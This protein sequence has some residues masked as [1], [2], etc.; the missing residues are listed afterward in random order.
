[1]IAALSTLVRTTSSSLVNS[2]GDNGGRTRTPETVGANLEDKT[3]PFPTEAHPVTPPPT[4]PHEQECI[5]S[6]TIAIFGVAA[7]WQ[8]RTLYVT[9]ELLCIG[10]RGAGSVIERFKLVDILKVTSWRASNKVQS[11]E[12]VIVKDE[13]DCCLQLFIQCPYS[14]A[15]GMGSSPVPQSTISSPVS[16]QSEAT[17]PDISDKALLTPARYDKHNVQI[18]CLRALSSDEREDWEKVLRDCVGRAKAAEIAARLPPTWQENLSDKYN[19]NISQTIV[20]TLVV[21]NF[22]ISIAEAELVPE[23][24]SQLDITL[25]SIDLTFTVIFA[26]ELAINLTAHWFWEFWRNSWNWLDFLVVLVSLGSIGT[27]AGPTIKI[28]RILRALRVMRLIKRLVA[29]RMIV[30]AIASSVIPVANVFFLL[31]L[32]TLVYAILGVGLFRDDS[33]E[34]FGN[35]SRY[36]R[37]RA[38]THHVACPSA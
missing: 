7:C 14:S 11:D 36:H 5:K 33:P 22:C 9:D 34:F 6:G 31:M 12:E 37:V 4:L 3:D 38:R 18:V 30:A 8:L 27:E 21:V 25:E 32:A 16:A 2:R 24:G 28:I 20:M 26:I 1:M 29:L 19:S 10:D 17:V 35:L 13:L 15:L 23:P